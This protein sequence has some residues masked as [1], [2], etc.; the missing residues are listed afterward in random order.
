MP[1]QPVPGAEQPDQYI[2]LLTNKKVALMVNHTS[3][4]DSIHL[5]DF[6]LANNI[7]IA[8][9][10]AVEHGFR[11][12]AA[13]G[14]EINSTVDEK[15]GLPVV[16]L[17]GKK[18]KPS[19]DDLNNIDVVVFDMQ[20]VGCRFYT[21]I[22]SM[23]YLMEACAENN[24]QVII[25]DRPNPNGDYIAGPV[26]NTDLK[27]FVGLH[28][29]PVVH[30]C[31]VGELAQMING[32]GWL[33]TRQKC[34]LSI[35]PVKHYSHKTRYTPPV[36]PSPNLPNYQAVR[37]YP[38]LCFF[39]ATNVS[40]GRGTDFPFQVIG[41]PGASGS[42]TFKPREIPG[43]SNNPLHENKTCTGIDLRTIKPVPEFTL[44]YFIDFYNQFKE[45]EN[46]WKSKRWI[47][48][49]SGSKELYHQINNGLSEDEIRDTWQKDLEQYKST[50]EKY[51]LYP[52]F[53]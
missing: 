14:E 19:S 50:R 39:E 52:D 32:E 27:S 8:K 13:N 9:V 26:L 25:L 1:V 40:I 51:L 15:T 16:S 53:E 36:K 22:S 20:D 12:Q 47:E 18:K 4:V 44:K 31:T 46:F 23:H 43:V 7:N 42:F 33:K 10:F 29:I 11:G 49:L 45:S 37:L 21:Y 6:L 3:M 48:L 30:G 24:V 34:S 17:Y 2:N 28:P 5:V 41:F 35:I 38:S